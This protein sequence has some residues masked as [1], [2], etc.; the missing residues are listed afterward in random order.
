MAR[1][2]IREMKRQLREGRIGQPTEEVRRLAAEAALALLERSV[3]MRHRRLAVQRLHDAVDLGVRLTAEQWTYCR[4]AAEASRD[5]DLRA[6]FQRCE[7]ALLGTAIRP[8]G[9]MANG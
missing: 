5:A 7:L 9:S 6:T 8:S 1:D 3:R 4:D 2:G